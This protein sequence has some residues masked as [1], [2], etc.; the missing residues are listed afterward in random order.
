MPLCKINLHQN[1]VVFI[2]YL[3][4]HVKGGTMKGLM[5]HIPLMVLIISIGLIFVLGRP[6]SQD[7]HDDHL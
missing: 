3:G 1:A 4:T 2:Q 5:I 7:D 6:Y